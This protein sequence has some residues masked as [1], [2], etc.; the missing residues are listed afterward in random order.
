[1]RTVKDS[2]KEQEEEVIPDYD[3]EGNSTFVYSDVLLVDSSRVLYRQ[4]SALV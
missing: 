4:Q 1:M 3:E 2:D